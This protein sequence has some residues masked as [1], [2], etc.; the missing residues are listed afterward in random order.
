MTAGEQ[1]SRLLKQKVA[2]SYSQN[3]DSE[4]RV[5]GEV[6]RYKVGFTKPALFVLIQ[7]ENKDNMTTTYMITHFSGD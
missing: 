4:L 7:V 1:S 5:C 2:R 3:L 6:G